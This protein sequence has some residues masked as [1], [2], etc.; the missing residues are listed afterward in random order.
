MYVCT[1]TAP[2]DHHLLVGLPY[3]VGG[4]IYVRVNMYIFT[5][6]VH[7]ILYIKYVEKYTKIV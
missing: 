6:T 7:D 2:T 3:R 1:V 4:P 5:D